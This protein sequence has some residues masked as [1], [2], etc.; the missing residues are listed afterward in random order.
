MPGAAAA[1]IAIFLPAFLFVAIAGG[2]AANGVITITYLDVAATD[3][4]MVLSKEV[5]SLAGSKR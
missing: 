3:P 5:R 4:S 1:T 2:V